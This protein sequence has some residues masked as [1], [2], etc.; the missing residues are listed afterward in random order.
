M[1]PPKGGTTNCVIPPE[2]GTTNCLPYDPDIISEP[3]FAGL[4]DFRD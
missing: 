2:G 4:K 1:I 3:R